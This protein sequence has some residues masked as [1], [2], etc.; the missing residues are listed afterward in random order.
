MV[1]GRVI[2]LFQ[3]GIRADLLRLLLFLLLALQVRSQT[4][5]FL[6]H[7]TRADAGLVGV[8]CVKTSPLVAHWSIVKVHASS[9]RVVEVHSGGIW[10]GRVE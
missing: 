9:R 10:I 8:P 7:Q 2:I 4:D 6:V 3:E 5:S 1:I